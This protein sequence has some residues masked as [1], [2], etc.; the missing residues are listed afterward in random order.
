MDLDT[1]LQ[2]YHDPVG[3]FA[4]HGCTIVFEQGISLLSAPG[5]LAAGPN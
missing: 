5:K 2:K 3:M 4:D 1:F